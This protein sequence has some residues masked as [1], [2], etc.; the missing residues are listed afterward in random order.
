MLVSCV[1]Q[2][3]LPL[4][5][6]LKLNKKRCTSLSSKFS[7]F[8]FVVFQVISQETSIVAR[9]PFARKER[10]DVETRRLSLDGAVLHDRVLKHLP[11][12]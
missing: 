10:T 3:H 1:E 2:F 5:P 12:T 4:V 6:E 7:S 11:P 9:D 8:D